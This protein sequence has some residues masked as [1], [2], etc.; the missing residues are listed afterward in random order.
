MGERTFQIGEINC[1]MSL[2]SS[3]IN[4]LNKGFKFIPNFN[5]KPI[6]VLYNIINTLEEEMFNLNKQ[7]FIKKQTLNRSNAVLTIDKN[8]LINLNLSSNESSF[9][10]DNFTHSSFKIF[11]DFK[12]KLNRK[13]N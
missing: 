3:I 11:L 13:N 5:L 1:D 2:K 4:I 8:D 12:R 9:F 7:F 6:H 10:D